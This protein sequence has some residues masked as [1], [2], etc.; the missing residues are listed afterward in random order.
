MWSLSLDDDASLAWGSDIWG[1]VEGHLK[2]IFGASGPGPSLPE[3]R[4]AAPLFLVEVKH[5]YSQGQILKV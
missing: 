4:V 2:K 1:F 3:G 5:L